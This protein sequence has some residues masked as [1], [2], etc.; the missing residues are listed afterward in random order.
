M[1]T[2]QTLACRCLL[3][4]ASLLP[5]AALAQQGTLLPFAGEGNLVVFDA[6]AGTGGWVGA[7]TQFSDPAMPLPNP[8]SLVSVVLFTFDS[9]AQTLNGS[10]EL[11]TTDLAGSLLG[12]VTGTFADANVFSSGGQLSLDYQV[13]SATGTLMGIS[14]Y[15]L[16]FLT[17]DPAATG[18]NNYS[19]DGLAVLAV[20]EPNALALFATGLLF[21]GLVGQRLRRKA[22]VQ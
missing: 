17:F 21:M 1:N 11:T 19:E 14:G 5:A 3:A 20:P 9:L 6:A 22:R 13:Q 7:V 2:F 10:F 15:G 12:T 16:S 8:V 4:V 18:L